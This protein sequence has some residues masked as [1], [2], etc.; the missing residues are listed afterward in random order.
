MEDHII[1]IVRKCAHITEFGIFALLVLRALRQP[2]PPGNGVW[3]WTQFAESLWLSLFYAATD[4]FHQTYVPFREGCIR[5]V[6]IDGF[7][8]VLGLLFIWMAGRWRKVW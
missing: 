7:G 2:L 4:E 8:A 1:T 5:D 3:H 6:M